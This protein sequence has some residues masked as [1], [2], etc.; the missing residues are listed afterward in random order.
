MEGGM[1]AYCLQ[2]PGIQV[3]ELCLNQATRVDVLPIQNQ[4]QSHLPPE[5]RQNHFQLA[6]L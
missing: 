3:S 6:P 2:K 5:L 1:Q 4:S